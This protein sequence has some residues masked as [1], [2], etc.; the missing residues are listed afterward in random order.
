MRRS[1]IVIGGALTTVGLLAAPA[2]AQEVTA[3]SV[4]AN[5]DI[6]F[7]M[8]CAA[9]V[10]L[11]HP[12]FALLETGLGRS[13][14]AA[15]IIMKNLM[16]LTLGIVTYYAVG[17]ALMYGTQIGGFIGTDGFFLKGLASYEPV[18][19]GSLAADFLFQAVF[20]ATAATIISG[21]CAERMKFGPYLATIMFIT[22][23]IY[24]IVGAWKW[25]GGWLADLGFLDF[26]GS[27]VVHLTG[28]VAALVGAAVL[29]PR[30]GKYA[31]DGTP[32]AILGHSMPLAM[33][34]ALLLFF[35]WF[36]FNGGSVLVADG[37]LVSS[38]L[39]N[40]ALAGAVGGVTSALFTRVRYGKY[41]V[42]MTGNGMLAGLVGVTAGADV[43]DN[44]GSLAVGIVAGVLVVLVVALVDRKVDDPVGAVAVHGACGA[45]GTLWVGLAHTT[46][47]LFYGGGAGLLGVQATG[48]VAVVA[49]VGL[50][51]LVFFSALKATVGI[52]VSE[53]EE[54][55]GLDLHEHGAYGYPELAM[56]TQAFPAGPRGD[57][58]GTIATTVPSAA[59]APRPVLQE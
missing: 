49:F 8:V 20:A 50:S 24:P 26:A 22:G 46:D 27:T 2:A 51:S 28:G 54:I 33:L 18:T 58:A 6:I 12:G 39:V 45:L 36:G 29:G 1:A 31:A 19:G 30:L 17:F 56:G 25:G 11:M 21:A 41:D 37:A 55:E 35:G 42:G 9:F 38:V 47:G 32:R 14:N 43:L 40:T 44:F 3:A 5:L 10:M 15:H 23:L 52:R 13:K 16:T 34:G 7:I 59:V 4:Q 53:T 57:L 48:V